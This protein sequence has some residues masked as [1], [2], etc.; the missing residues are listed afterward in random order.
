[1]ASKPALYQFP[2]LFQR[3]KHQNNR[4]AQHLIRLREKKQYR[5]QE[6]TLLIQG[7]AMVR[8]MR[9]SGVPLTSLVVTAMEEPYSEEAIK[10]PALQVIQNPDA[11]NAQHHY[12]VDVDLSRR[13]LGT[14]A[15]PGRHEVFA[16]IPLPNHSLPPADKVDR[17]MVLDHVNDPSDLGNLVRTGKALGWGSGAITTPLCDLYNLDTVRASRTASLKWKYEQVYVNDLVAFL[18]SYDMTPLVADTLPATPT[19]D[20]WSPL[21]GKYDKNR[22]P[23][24]VGS[25]PWLWNFTNNKQMEF[26]KRPALILS[27]AHKGL[28]GLDDEIR[29]GMPM[30]DSIESLNVVSVGSLLMNEVNRLI[31]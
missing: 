11:F 8:D 10:F 17:M 13:I 26:P 6:G 22:N 25:G 31:K 7:L 30:T 3:V 1:M 2:R 5:H 23:A 28:Q 21:T 24:T 19:E 16:E 29:I 12:L 4:V 20:L 18:K 9:D 14:A 15:R 27:A